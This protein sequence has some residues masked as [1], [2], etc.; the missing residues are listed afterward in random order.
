MAG[1]TA[2]AS[3][4]PPVDMAAAYPFTTAL[5]SQP[6]TLLNLASAPA[7]AEAG[8]ADQGAASRVPVADRWYDDVQVRTRIFLTGSVLAV[9]TYGALKWWDDGFTGFRR[10][11]EGWF[12]ARTEKGG[13][14][15]L[16]HAFGT[17]TGARAGAEALELLGNSREDAV[18]L[19]SA[20]SLAVYMGIEVLDGFSRQYRFSAEDMAANVLGAGL[21]YVLLN[22]PRADAL[23]DF[24]LL[25][26]QSPEAR[27]EGNWAP[28][29]DY[30]GQKYLLAFKAAAVP[31]LDAN[32]ALRYLELAVGYGVRGYDP[33]AALRSRHVYAG[34]ALNLSRVLDDTV[35]H[36]RRESLARRGT[37]LFLE[38]FQLPG[39]SIL[40]NR[41]L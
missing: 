25:Y 34:V 9:G 35:F 21:A 39:T 3:A 28:F 22:N 14:D 24:R 32:P 17:Y 27:V 26:R 10:Q 19:A 13:A 36:G 18:R 8:K 30:N 37:A 29:A 6:T 33:P 38:L 12:G 4:Q 23:I 7:R 5:A 16:G 31:A 11:S 40:A 1:C 15:K 41:K 20:A 2:L